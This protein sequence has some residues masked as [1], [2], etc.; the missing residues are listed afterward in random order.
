M[1]RL[2]TTLMLTSVGLLATAMAQAEVTTRLRAG[3]ALAG[4]YEVVDSDNI[5]TYDADYTAVPVG[6]TVYFG[7]AMYADVA[8]QSASGDAT[9]PWSRQKTDF[10]RTDLTISFGMNFDRLNTYVGYKQGLT[11]T[12]WPGAAPPDEFETS[13]VVFGGGFAFPMGRSAMSLGFGM[14]FL[15]GTYTWAPGASADADYTL[16]YSLSAGY[17][18]AF[19]E[20]FSASADYRW[21]SYSF[22]FVDDDFT[23]DEIFQQ[24]TI[25]LSY[26]F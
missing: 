21:N 23:I 24:A 15:S 11:E 5:S 19:N 3:V 8:Y 9:F 25:S 12:D 22:D 13:G 2:A 18:F 7:D 16:G 6:V 20:H 4:G 17:S 1:K 10:S 26:S 14:G